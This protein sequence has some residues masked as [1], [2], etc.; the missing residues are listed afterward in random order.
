MNYQIAMIIFGLY[1]LIHNELLIHNN[2]LSKDFKVVTLRCFI[3]GALIAGG[4]LL[5]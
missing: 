1:L 3:G 2:K 4:A 5:W